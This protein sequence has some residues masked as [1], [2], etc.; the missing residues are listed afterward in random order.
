MSLLFWNEDAGGVD[1]VG[2]DE[3]LSL[4]VDKLKE[5]NCCRY[6]KRSC[7][8]Y[9]DTILQ[10]HKIE[11][12]LDWIVL[13]FAR[14]GDQQ[15][16]WTFWNFEIGCKCQQLYQIL[17]IC[18]QQVLLK[19]ILPFHNLTDANVDFEVLEKGISTSIEKILFFRVLSRHVKQRIA[20]TS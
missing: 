6:Q 7:W 11:K 20:R 19:S 16:Q 4:W 10:R 5:T 15:Q 9:Q 18:I 2:N 14:S 3:P 13:C 12:K 8:C 17:K 1:A